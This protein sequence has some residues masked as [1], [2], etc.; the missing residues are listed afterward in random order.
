MNT[1]LRL[2][3]SAL[4]LTLT[5]AACGQ[6]HGT[7]PSADQDLRRTT[8][9]AVSG[10]RV[11]VANGVYEL[12]SRAS[13][14]A[15]DLDVPSGAAQPWATAHNAN[16]RWRLTLQAGG[17]Y[18]IES[19]AG[20]QVLGVEGASLDDGARVT[21]RPWTAGNNQRWTISDAG[22]G[23]VTLTANH[24]G[25]VMDV[26]EGRVSDGARVQ[27]WSGGGGK[28]QQWKLR[29]VGR[30]A[31]RTL[32]VAKNGKEDGDGSATR[33]FSS[34]QQAVD[35]AQAGDVVLVGDGEYREGVW[36]ERQG[37][38]DAWIALRAQHQ[39]RAK[40]IAPG[41]KS[42]VFLSSAA[43][44]V[45]VGGFDI[46]TEGTGAGISGWAPEHTRLLGNPIHDSGGGGINIAHGDHHFIADN[47]LHQSAYT[48]PYQ[49]S[50]ISVWEPN[51]AD[52]EPGF[53]IVVRNNVSYSNENKG[54]G[55]GKVGPEV[56]DGNGIIIDSFR[57]TNDSGT[58]PDYVHGALVENNLVY[59][60]G[61]A[62]VRVFLSDHVTVR[63]NTA[64]GNY[65][66]TGPSGTYKGELSNQ[67]GS[68][69]I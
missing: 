32:Y 69:N 66:A 54:Q 15:L 16:Q 63:H 51:A 62:G 49:T 45:E 9:Q 11:Q 20:A 12:E 1:T 8:P 61:G 58:R 22:D 24:S 56:S 28:N 13:G 33:P 6:T 39:Q 44:Y 65:R 17:A 10:A 42:G 27:Q 19:L 37:R 30:P 68:H 2:G 57:A 59:D 48:N 35:T 34:I 60:N 23:S 55:D 36:V 25:K 21:A 18:V 14:K 7:P 64:Y 3:A 53:H 47:A 4:I 5:L 29:L 43:R 67:D 40:I 31:A 41:D 26:Q 50:G 52:D 46:S 38:A